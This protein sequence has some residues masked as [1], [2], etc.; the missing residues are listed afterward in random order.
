MGQVG[1]LAVKTANNFAAAIPAIY[2]GATG[3]RKPVHAI[4]RMPA[5]LA[6]VPFVEG[7]YASQVSGAAAIGVQSGTLGFNLTGSNSGVSF[8]IPAWTPSTGVG[9]GAFLQIPFRGS[10][11]GIACRRDTAVLPFSV[12]ID[13]DWY[14]ADSY[15]PIFLNN[16]LNPVTGGLDWVL[17]ADDLDPY[18]PHIATIAAVSNP[19]VASPIRLLHMILDKNAGYA[20]ES[21][22]S[23]LAAS[24][25]LTTVNSAIQSGSVPNRIRVVDSIDFYNADAAAQ[26]VSI[27]LGSTVIWA[28]SIVAGGTASWPEVGGSAPKGILNCVLGSV[29]VKATVNTNVIYNV[30]GRTY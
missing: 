28:K 19:Q 8:D 22:F 18:V 14:P 20:D 9:N 27:T 16:G 15:L 23:Y 6:R 2:D 12:G 21:K 13:S 24:G 4:D 1:N 25:A 10:T 30:W 5:N 11:F 3:T 29:F 17:V 7:S 26:T